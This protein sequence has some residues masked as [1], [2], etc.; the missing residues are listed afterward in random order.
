MF[1]KPA[2]YPLAFLSLSFFIFS[3]KPKQEDAPVI[4]K[5]CISDTM[6]KSVKI[7]S[8]QLGT[9][10]DE[11]KLSGEVNFD[12]K[13]VTRV[14]AFSSGQVVKVNVSVGDKVSRGQVLA[15]IKSADIAG[16]YSDLATAG[17][18]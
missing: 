3:C 15:I 11:L 2:K 7:D 9:M 12:D 13:K 17:N 18:D 1:L 4:K 8:A 6:A 14:F 10:G 16:N 5:I